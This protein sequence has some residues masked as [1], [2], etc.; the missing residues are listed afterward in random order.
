MEK[1]WITIILFALAQ[2]TSNLRTQAL[3]VGQACDGYAPFNISNFNI[4]PWPPV[5]NQPMTLSMVGVFQ[6]PVTVAYLAVGQSC[7][8]Q[9]W[10]YTQYPIN[11][12]FIAG[13]P[14]T[15]TQQISS[16]STKGN[17]YLQVTLHGAPPE[18]LF[19]TCWEVNY[20]LN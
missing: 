19:V 8:Y 18:D 3:K 4:S 13:Q 7:N 11:Q 9:N 5:F 17:C 12:S 6:M 10:D 20:Q 16:G 2:S 1:I 14:K 15:F